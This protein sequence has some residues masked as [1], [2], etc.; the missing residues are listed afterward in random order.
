MGVQMSLQ[1]TSFIS[2]EYILI[3]K[4]AGQ[5]GSFIFNFWDTYTLFS[6]IYITTITNSIQGLHFLYS[7]TSTYLSQFDNN[8]SYRMSDNSMWFWFAFLWWLVRLSSFHV[9]VVHLYV[10]YFRSFGILK[11]GYFYA[12]GVTI[13]I[14]EF[15]NPSD[16]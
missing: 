10:F 14:F 9:P 8:S 7:L 16:V 3:H 15:L 13:D 5:Y 11:S 4:I 12:E 2:F 6:L 1:H